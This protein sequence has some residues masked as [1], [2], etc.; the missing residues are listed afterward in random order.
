MLEDPDALA[1][2]PGIREIMERES[3][4]LGG[5][6]G[7]EFSASGTDDW[8]V[9][10]ESRRTPNAAA[11]AAL[12]SRTAA[13]LPSP[14]A[15]DDEGGLGDDDA[16]VEESDPRSHLNLVFIGHVDAGKV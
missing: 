5:E 15:N 14:M 2:H 13:S 9:A 7:P 10:N 12:T 16:V 8:D 3:S 4:E 11:D 1:S 6:A